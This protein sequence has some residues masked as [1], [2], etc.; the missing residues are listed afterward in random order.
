MGTSSGRESIR[1]SSL[2]Y[3]LFLEKGEPRAERR[4]FKGEP[5]VVVW[6][7]QVGDSTRQAVREVFRFE[8]LEGQISR[9]CFFGFCPETETEILSTLELPFASLGYGVW[10][11]EFNRLRREEEFVKWRASQHPEWVDKD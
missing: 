9:L 8:E 1:D 10:A 11:P 3:C 7:D 6:Y 2:Y 5:I 4:S